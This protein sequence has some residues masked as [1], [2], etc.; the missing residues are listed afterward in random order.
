MGPRLDD[1]RPSVKE[2]KE[3]KV[4]GGMRNPTH[5]R[6]KPPEAVRITAALLGGEKA[7]P[8]DPAFIAKLRELTIKVLAPDG[9]KLPPKATKASTPISAEVLWA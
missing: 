2:L 3:L 9:V 8:M 6:R 7:E 4:L 1:E 5:R